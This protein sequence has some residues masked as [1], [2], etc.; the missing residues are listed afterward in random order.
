MKITY[1]D[2]YDK[3][4]WT[5][6]K[7]YH[8][9]K[10]ERIYHGP[11]L[12]W[13]GFSFVADALAPL[14]PGKTLLDIGCGGGDLARRFMRKGYDA[15]GVDI[16]THATKN[17]VPEMRGRV[18]LCDVTNPPEKIT[19]L[20]TD[21]AREFPEQF[22]VVLAT[23]LMEHF[24]E[25]DLDQAFSYILNKSKRWIF[26]CI[27]TTQQFEAHK[28]EFVAKKGEPIPPEFE[29]CAVAGHLNVRS[30][31]QYWVPYFTKKWNL[32]IRW[33]LLYFFQAV[34]EMNSAWKQTGGWNMTTCVLIDK[35]TK[36]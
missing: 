34:R 21:N 32:T 6:Q 26:M 30:Y 13:E 23:D 35:L 3:A 12:E 10:E 25:E 9:G 5:G 17:C 18:A 36:Q 24:Y 28:S 20:H 7:T 27:A 2:W 22:D 8:D 16:S 31:Y 4:Y 33:D 19:A 11:A 15:Y 29:P 1:E 14:V